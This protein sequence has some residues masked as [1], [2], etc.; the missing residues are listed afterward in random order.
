MGIKNKTRTKEARKSQRFN[1]SELR[2]QL[3]WFIYKEKSVYTLWK[4]ASLELGFS[5]SAMASGEVG[6]VWAGRYC[7]QLVGEVYTLLVSVETCDLGVSTMLLPQALDG[8][9]NTAVFCFMS[10]VSA[11]SV[12]S[13]LHIT[14]LI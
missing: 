13:K 9:P 1:N 11:F 10:S 5:E 3:Y 2:L 4:L 6:G 7:S 8:E 14:D 12:L